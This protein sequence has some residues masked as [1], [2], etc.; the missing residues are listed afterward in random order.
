MSY[1][2]WVKLIEKIGLESLMNRG[3]STIEVGLTEVPGQTALFQ[4]ELPNTNEEFL[5]VQ[6]STRIEDPYPCLED[7]TSTSIL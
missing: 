2:L 1:F 6:K 3:I 5:E 4:R 7:I